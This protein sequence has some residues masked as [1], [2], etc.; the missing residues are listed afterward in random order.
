MKSGPVHG[1]AD[2]THGRSD[3]PEQHAGQHPFGFRF[4]QDAA[5]FDEVEVGHGSGQLVSDYGR[6][7][8]GGL[9]AWSAHQ[10][11]YHPAR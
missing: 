8:A 3:L 11:F 6:N 1:H 9:Q 2:Q 5:R 7:E 4:S 10:E